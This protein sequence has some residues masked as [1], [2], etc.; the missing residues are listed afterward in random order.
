MHA[1]ITGANGFLGTWLTQRLSSQGHRVRRLVRR[2]SPSFLALPNEVEDVLGDVTDSASLKAALGEIDVVF[3]LAG[4]R[5]APDRDTFFRINAEGTRVLCEAMS[6]AT[7]SR[8]VFCGSLAASGPST[9][10]RPREESDDLAPYEWYGE[11]KAEAER[12]AFSYGDRFA[13][14]SIRPARILGPGDRE[15]LIFFKLTSRGIKL[16]VGGGPRPL[17]MVDVDDVVDL[18]LLMAERPEAVGQAFFSAAPE[19]TTL[20]ALQDVVAQRLGVRARALRCSPRML[21]AVAS[22][23]DLV[24]QVTGR[25]LPLNRKLARQLLSPAWTCSVEKARTLLGHVPKRTLAESVQRSLEWYRREG[26][27]SRN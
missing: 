10:E 6:S 22:A 9:T 19:T 7:A 11:S 27:L 15:N 26:W 25:H 23:A 18:M 5:R 12:I 2:R 21:T 20:E 4:V 1:L 8:L 14:T 24:S 13:V 17:S 3:H 16:V